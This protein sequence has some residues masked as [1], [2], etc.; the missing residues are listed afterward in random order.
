MS[1][2]GAGLSRGRVLPCDHSTDHDPVST[3]HPH[4]SISENMTPVYVTRAF[5]P[6][7]H[8]R[9][10]AATKTLRT[11]HLPVRKG[12]QNDTSTLAD[13]FDG[14]IR[15]GRLDGHSLLFDL[16]CGYR[17]WL[18]SNAPLACTQSKRE[19]VWPQKASRLVRHDFADHSTS[20][21]GIEQARVKTR[22]A[23]AD[24]LSCGSATL[25]KG[26]SAWTNS[27]H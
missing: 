19:V 6:F 27:I 8:S 7:V 16:T 3:H 11:S 15:R 17:N 24:I 9:H 1:A 14:G 26:A 5:P 18:R 25:S 20:P 13:R 23:S 21:H 10:H 2:G 22:S 4:V 12:M